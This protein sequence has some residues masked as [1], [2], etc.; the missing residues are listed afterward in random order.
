MLSLFFPP[1][2]PP[3]LSFAFTVTGARCRYTG[4]HETFSSF[5]DYF[6]FFALEGGLL[7]RF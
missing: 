1:L 3:G 4:R 5:G 7:F 6:F 2:L